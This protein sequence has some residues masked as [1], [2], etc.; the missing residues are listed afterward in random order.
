MIIDG[1]LKLVGVGLPNFTVSGALG[2][3]ANTV[4]KCSAFMIAQ[5]TIGINITLPT[6]TDPIPQMVIIA[7]TGTVTLSVEGSNIKPNGMLTFFFN[8]LTWSIEGSNK[9]K[10]YTTVMNLVAGANTVTHNLNLP[11][12]TFSNYMIAARRSTGT[13]LSINTVPA[14]DTANSLVINAT[15]A[16]A[17]VRIFVQAV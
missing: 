11:A 15:G 6:P 9:T 4:D 16:I 12:G 17:N 13:D 7:N 8:G 5:S 1:F 14:S 3:A 2:T 10:S